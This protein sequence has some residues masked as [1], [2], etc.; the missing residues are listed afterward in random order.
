MP[1]G[2]GAW[3]ELDLAPVL[4]KPPRYWAGG[5]GEVAE[6]TEDESYDL[7]DRFGDRAKALCEEDAMA[8]RRPSSSEVQGAQVR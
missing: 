2:W 5:F 3:A 7:V 4:I 1:M 8:D 6:E